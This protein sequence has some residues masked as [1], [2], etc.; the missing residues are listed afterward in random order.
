VDWRDLDNKLS[1]RGVSRVCPICGHDE[2]WLHAERVVALAL[3]EE[4]A[5]APGR[6]VQAAALG[7]ENCGYIRLH[8]LQVLGIPRVEPKQP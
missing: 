7:C 3:V 5:E 2:A 4:E 1:S 8:N 6:A